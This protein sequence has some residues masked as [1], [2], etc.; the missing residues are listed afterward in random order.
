MDNRTTAI[1]M[2]DG[3]RLDEP[4]PQKEEPKKAASKLPSAG[5]EPHT[6]QEAHDAPWFGARVSNTGPGL[7]IP[8]GVPLCHSYY[9]SGMGAFCRKYT[10]LT[11]KLLTVL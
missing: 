2:V 11:A 3:S 9:G 4:Q 1:P 6:N 8:G 10:A 5:L 7:A